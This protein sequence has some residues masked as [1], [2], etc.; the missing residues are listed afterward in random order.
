M[1][2]RARKLLLSGIMATAVI[3]GASTL[4]VADPGTGSKAAGDIPFAVEDFNYPGA[5]KIQ[6]EQG[7]TLI[8]GDGHIT[9]AA[10]DDTA[11]QLK[12]L[13]RAG[14]AGEFC[15]TATS[16]TGYLTLELAD[17]Y[18][19]QTESHPV[20]AELSAEGKTQTVNVAKN[21]FQG[22]GE[23]IG[24]PATVLLELRITG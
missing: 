1:I 14:A 12:V 16:T 11:D 15:F 3:A 13:T 19:I 24:E 18:A 2:S 5:D 9:L 8:R 20:R 21:A 4:A 10:C 17:V 22:V 7:I 6:A 23:G